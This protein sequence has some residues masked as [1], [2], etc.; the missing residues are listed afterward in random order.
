MSFKDDKFCVSLFAEVYCKRIILG[1]QNDL[2]A[3][4]ILMRDV[5]CDRKLKNFYVYWFQ[6]NEQTE[7]E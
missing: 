6:A 4:N 3:R 7:T 5:F 2:I 1:A